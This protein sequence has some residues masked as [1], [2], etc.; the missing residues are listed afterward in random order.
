MEQALNTQKVW[1]WKIVAYLFLLGAGAGIYLV[2][3]YLVLSKLA[4]ILAAPVTI[5][6]ALLLLC[7]TGRKGT[8]YRA[9]ARPLSSWIA[10]GAIIITVFII[11]NL[12]HIFAWA[13]PSTWLSGAPDLHRALGVIASIF[14]VLALVYTGLLLRVAKPIP[15]WNTSFLPGIFLVSGISTG[16]MAVA[17]SLSVYGL[18]T[19]S[20]MAQP[21]ILLARFDVFVI[22]VEALIICFYLWR[23]HQLKA[24][25][26]SVHMVTKGSLA[27]PFWGGVVAAGLVVPFAF[28]V[29]K[30]YLSTIDPVAVLALTAV[31]SII[32]LMG[33]FML[34][35]IVVAGGT[36]TPLNVE[37][38]L[39]SYPDTYRVKVLRQAT[40]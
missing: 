37:G 8:F 7:D 24:A 19:G 13:W 14:A 1:G 36:S 33:G 18:S 35:Y 30:T 23:M 26:P 10:R 34:R 32:G 39:I 21:L 25:R 38:V 29:Y 12:I 9:F 28:E 6:G 2:G 16:T 5:I 22:V 31:A 40:F 11:L 15:F 3:F 20:A 4:V 17:L 27:A